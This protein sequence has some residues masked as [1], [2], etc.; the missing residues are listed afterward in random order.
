MAGI[1]DSINQGLTRLSQSP[2][3]MASMGLLMMPQKSLEP[4]NPLQYAMQG[5]QAGIQNQ[6]RAQM[7]ERQQQ[8][9]ARRQA[10]FYYLAREYSDK[11]LKARQEEAQQQAMLNSISQYSTGLTDPVK[12][13]AF[14]ALPLSEKAKIISAEQFPN[15]QMTSGSLPASVQEYQFAQKDPEYFK[16]LKE[17]A[18]ITPEAYAASTYQGAMGRQLGKVEGEYTGRDKAAVVAREVAQGEAIGSEAGKTM[19]KAA[20][21]L[22]DIEASAQYTVNILDQLGNHP[23]LQTMVGMP[24]LGKSKKFASGS[25]ESDFSILLA[26]I[27]GDKFLAAVQKLRGTGQITEMEGEKAAAAIAR[28]STA[29]SE[30]A[31]IKALNEYR[32]YIQAGVQRARAKA[33]GEPL[34]IIPGMSPPGGPS[35]TP[36]QLSPAGGPSGAPFQL[37]PAGQAAFEKY[38]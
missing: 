22:P 38:R 37:S 16:W 34:S 23:A 28:M 31:F 14:N 33:R 1:S 29:Q 15:A 32:G 24:S 17:R 19:A 13:L 36:V 10:E 4:I 3:G 11:F 27:N 25:P 6:Q 35:G 26:Q 8:E 30:Q 18:K 2:L 5:M 9:E 7:M 20:F 12:R 21:D